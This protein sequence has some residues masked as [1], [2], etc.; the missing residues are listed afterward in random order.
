MD[1]YNNLFSYL[2]NRAYN[3][4]NITFTIMVQ[5][6]AFIYNWIIK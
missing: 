2:Y 3:F 6:N 1:S 4:F 5:N